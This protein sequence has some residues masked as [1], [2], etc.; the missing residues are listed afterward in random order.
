ML[1]F[2]RGLQYGEDDAQNQ[3]IR[4]VKKIFRYFDIKSKSSKE[5]KSKRS[6]QV[7]QRFREIIYKRR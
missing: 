4:I 2:R 6:Y 5:N 7:C 3:K 1:K